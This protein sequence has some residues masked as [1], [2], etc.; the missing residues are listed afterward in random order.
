M[1]KLKHPNSTFL[2]AAA[3]L[4]LM[5]AAACQ[6]DETYSL[7]NIKNLDTEMT[8]FSNTLEVPVGNV[9]MIS[10]G[11]IIDLK[12]NELVYTDGDGNYG[13]RVSGAEAT[14]TKIDVPSVSLSPFQV[15]KVNLFSYE[16]PAA[17]VG[18]SVPSLSQDMPVESKK[19]TITIENTLP[20]EMVD[21]E[22]V[23]INAPI[24]VSFAVS[25][26][27]VTIKQG[28]SFKFPTCLTLTSQSSDFQVISGNTLKA[29][30]DIQV[31]NGY[32]FNATVTKIVVPAGA[33][34]TSGNTR[35]LKITDEITSDGTVNISGA[36][37]STIPASVSFDFNVSTGNVTV[38]SANAKFSVSRNSDD[39]VLSVGAL[40]DAIREASL[41]LSDPVVHFTVTNGSPFEVVLNATISSKKNGSP[42]CSPISLSG[43]KVAASVTTDVYICKSSHAVPAG[44][45]KVA[46]DNIGQILSTIPDEFAI[47]GL[48]A[49]VQTPGFVTISTSSSYTVGVSYD[50]STLLAFET[51]TALG[52]NYTF[53]GL[54]LEGLDDK[55]EIKDMDLD[56]DFVSSIPLDLTINAKAYDSKGEEMSGAQVN[57]SATVKGGSLS[58]PATSPVTINIKAG[59]SFSDLDSIVLDFR[60]AVPAALSGIAL[61]EKQGIAIDNIV[62]RVNGGVTVKPEDN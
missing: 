43:V 15:G 7:D 16:F 9:K 46:A 40:P 47:T 36:A 22:S 21:L 39:I 60:A 11:S 5:M 35:K 45:V 19:S 31:S 53:E 3:L 50:V 37:F 55:L 51:G 52:F 44:A 34:T 10:L 8:L 20:N 41:I 14:S 61:N 28:F 48:S 27:Y 23:T 30:K 26:G 42:V 13:I 59:E 1:Q 4:A 49:T 62:M 2:P 58:S 12:D 17:S 18:M 57:V 38:S 32:K 54:S 24:E 29:T 25:S 56:M 6:V 33:I